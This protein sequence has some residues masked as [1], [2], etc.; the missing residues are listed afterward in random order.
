MGN[1]VC[2][3]GTA[4]ARRGAMADR[5][6]KGPGK[7]K[8]EEPAVA[9]S[10]ICSHFTERSRL[11][12]STETGTAPRFLW[13]PSIPGPCTEGRVQFTGS[14]APGNAMQTEEAAAASSVSRSTQTQES[15]PPTIPERFTPLHVASG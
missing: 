11:Q 1:S 14:P 12:R 8:T 4:P 10:S 3:P 7:R 5:L 13:Q 2:S 9:G 15:E 6:A